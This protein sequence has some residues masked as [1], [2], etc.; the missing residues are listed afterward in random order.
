MFN[1][2]TDEL[3]L[4]ISICAIL[5]TIISFWYNSLRTGVPIFACSR[6]T[7]IGLD[8]SGQQGSSFVIKIGVINYG[9]RP[10]LINDFL[11]IAETHNNKKIVYDPIILFDLTFYIASIGKQN[12]MTESQKGQIPLP[13]IIPPN[14]NYNFDYE[15]L[16][17]PYDKKTSIIN[18]QDSPF[19]LKLYARL[20][21]ESY[22]L[23]AEQ[24]IKKEDIASLTNGSFCGVLSSTSTEHREKFL[25][26]ENK[27]SA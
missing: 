24:V 9:N 8:N 6:W 23:I 26:K 25:N 15:I 17:M 5:V 10:L 21:K 3:A 22:K 7:A 19:T 16:F 13:I 27:K 18:N 14:K 20:K 2:N 11:L 4:I 12:R 1:L